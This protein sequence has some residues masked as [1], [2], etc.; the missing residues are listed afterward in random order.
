MLSWLFT[1]CQ[2]FIERNTP[3]SFWWFAAVL[4]CFCRL[5]LIGRV[6][7]AETDSYAEARPVEDS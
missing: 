1:V 6:M 7:S 3:K 5:G 4:C 2:D